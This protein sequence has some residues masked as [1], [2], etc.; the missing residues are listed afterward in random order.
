MLGILPASSRSP[1]K[2]PGPNVRQSHKTILIWVILIL[3]FVSIYSMF[4]DS[5]SKEK[6]IDVTSFK[7]ELQDPKKAELIDKVRIEPRGRNDAKYIITKK[8]G[9]SNEVVYG[10]YPENIPALLSAAN[11]DYSVKAK[12]ESSIWPQILLS[13]LPM[14]FLFAIFFFFMR[15]L[16]A[17]GGKAMSFGK[18]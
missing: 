10:E 13:W 7:A 3:M 4:T 2:G 15:Q 16:Q 12:D 8:T 11:V 14:L 18:S 9:T 5:S 6:E 17:G 1:G